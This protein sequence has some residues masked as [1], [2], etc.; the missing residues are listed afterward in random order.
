MRLLSLFILAGAASMIVASCSPKK[1][2]ISIIPRPTFV[3][4]RSGR[5]NI[6]EDLKIIIDKEETKGVAF[7]LTERIKR[8][9]GIDIEVVENLD[10]KVSKNFMLMILVDSSADLGK[11]GYILDIEKNKIVLRAE[12]PSGLFYGVQTILQL[13]PPEVY[14]NEVATDVK[15]SMPCLK[16]KDI[17]RYPYRGMH[18]DV[19]RHFFPV[20][21][22]KKYLDYMAMHKLNT[23]H[24]HLTEDQGWRIEIKKYPRLTQI[25]A[26]RKETLIGHAR[27][28]PHR[29]DGRRYGGF[30][31]RQQIREIVQ[32]AKDRFITVIPEIE[33]PGH[34]MAALASY[35][36]L[37]CTG[38]PFE[39]A[40]RWGVFRD[41]YCAGNDKV[42]KF[43]EDV[44]SEVIELFPSKYIHIGGDEC[45]KERWKECP[46]C[47]A[48]IKNEGLKDEHELQSYFIKRIEEFLISKGK[49]LIG[50][51]EILEGGL[52]PEATVMSWRGMRGGIEAARQGHD[53]IMTPTTYCYFDYYQGDPGKE[54]LAIGGYLP[55][56][57][58]Y[59]FEPTPEELTEEQK[60]HILGGQANLWTEYIATEDYAEYMVLPR[61]SALAEVVWTPKEE[62]DIIDFKRRLQKQYKRFIAMKA[63]FRIPQPEI[64]RT[65]VL[66]RG[67]GLTLESPMEIGK[68]H[69]TL[70]GSEPTS[71]SPRYKESIRFSENTILKT[72]VVSPDGRRSSITTTQILIDDF[73]PEGKRFG[74]DY[75]YYE[76]EFKD[77][78]PDFN[79]LTP[80]SSGHVNYLSLDEIIKREDGFAVKFTGYIKID[81]EGEYKFSVFADDGCRLLIDGNFVTGN[82]TYVGRV[83]SGTV[84]LKSGLHPIS[85]MYYESD[86]AERLKMWMEGPGIKENEIGAD[87]FLS[88]R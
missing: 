59:R 56:E 10:E 20:S 34:S 63:N 84:F 70:D 23:F 48:R 24:W 45:P 18:L 67:E 42:F 75:D 41:V 27:N 32:Y 3:E 54:P 12:Q 4:Q 11:E 17:P 82:N 78:I 86:G 76:G 9:A 83:V 37:S 50:W 47:Q 79:N 55:L 22:I 61:M 25:G 88:D 77:R 30:Y 72:C 46:K 6:T 5:F 65:L 81:R 44:L 74:L 28:L 38:G 35:P 8:A 52:A 21:F 16:I 57:K 43:L 64:G 62:R 80:K 71:E 66:K 15:W 31:T 73:A 13:L 33:M 1:E 36:E 40:T 51:D 85:I 39:V 19:C 60:K 58:V 14:S 49:R 69:Y 26:Y 7:Y 53:V 68:L 2:T 29:Y 87:M